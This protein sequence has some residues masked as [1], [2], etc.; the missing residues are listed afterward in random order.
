M[1]GDLWPE[2]F[3]EKAHGADM[4]TPGETKKDM[5]QNQMPAASM[6]VVPAGE[7]VSTNEIRPPTVRTETATPLQS[8]RPLS[9][10]PQ[11]ESGRITKM[12]R[13]TIVSDRPAL[14]TEVKRQPRRPAWDA[15][16]PMGRIDELAAMDLDTWRMLDSDPRIAAG[17]ILGKI[18]SL[19]QESFTRK[20][21][22][23]AAWRGSDVYRQYMML[24]ER[25]L[26]TRRDVAD[27]IREL[28]SKGADT[29]SIDEFE[30][31]SDLNR[32]LR[33]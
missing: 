5:A 2:S 21:Q 1:P 17:K 15:G 14:I 27:I 25:S 12:Q 20:S 23:I 28:R 4:K 32:M 10:L 8:P 29:L 6:P 22:G 18:Q 31:I 26:E 30:A 33:F 16:K 13:P 19:E 3:V 11:V 24:G 9:P 7:S